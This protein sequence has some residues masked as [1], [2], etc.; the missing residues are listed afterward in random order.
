MIELKFKYNII[1][2]FIEIHVNFIE[3]RSDMSLPYIVTCHIV[4]FISSYVTLS[5]ANMSSCNMHFPCWY[6]ISFLKIP[7]IRKGKWFCWTF[8]L[9]LVI[10]W[11]TYHK[12]YDCILKFLND[13]V[14]LLL[15]RLDCV[16]QSMLYVMKVVSISKLCRK[17][18]HN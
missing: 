16:Q 13:I 5:Y 12:N 17:K 1:C 11:Q 10:K 14:Y 3:V 6:E 18:Q 7:N 2:P 9:S 15:L 8:D 4:Q